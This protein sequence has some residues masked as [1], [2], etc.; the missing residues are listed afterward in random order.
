MDEAEERAIRTTRQFIEALS[1]KYVEMKMREAFEWNDSESGHM[2]ADN[3]MCEVLAQ[4]GYA[5][6]V[7]VFKQA[8]KYYA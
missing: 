6:A 8:F 3:L 1:P 7:K 5:E 4:W 2:M